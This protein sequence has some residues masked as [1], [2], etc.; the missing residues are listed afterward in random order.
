LINYA[1][2]VALNPVKNPVAEIVEQLK[3][4]TFDGLLALKAGKVNGLVEALNACMM[5][6]FSLSEVIAGL[7]SY[8]RHS[9]VRIL[10]SSK[11]FYA[12]FSANLECFTESKNPLVWKSLSELSDEDFVLL[13]DKPSTVQLIESFNPVLRVLSCPKETKV[14]KKLAKRGK[15]ADEE[16][17]ELNGA[18]L[19][20]APMFREVYR[21]SPH[22]PQIK[23]APVQAAAQPAQAKVDEVIDVDF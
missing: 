17:V 11:V 3:K 19:L 9:S 14:Y 22:Y 15:N 12:P 6:K 21:L 10:A 23:V 1:R 7:K 2:E 16:Y 5:E 18:R 8:D 13:G 20:A 4:P